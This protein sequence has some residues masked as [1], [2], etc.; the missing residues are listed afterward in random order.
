MNRSRRSRESGQATLFI[1]L[2]LGLFL[3]GSLCLAFDLSNMWFHRQAAQTAADAACTAGAMD[4]LVDAQGGATGHQGFTPGTAFDCTSGGRPGSSVC[5]YALKNGYDSTNAANGNLVSVSFPA[6]A[7]GVD[8]PPPSIAPTPFIRVDVLD[9]VQTF[10]SG[11]LSGSTTQ[12]VRTFSTCGV[13]LA[14]AP[15]PLIVLDPRDTDGPTLDVQGNPVVSIYGG[16]QRS[17]QVNSSYIGAVN[18]GGSASVDLSHGGP[19]NP[20][21]GSDL[22]VYGGPVTAPGGFN[23]GTTGNWVAPAAPINDPFA[24]V[25]APAKPGAPVPPAELAALG[26]ACSSVPCTVNFGVNGCP[27]ATCFE[28]APGYYPGGIDVQGPGGPSNFKAAIFDPGIY[29]IEN[30]FTARSNSCL[31]PSTAL[32][33]GSGGTLFYFAGT[34]SISVDSNSGKKCPNDTATY[35]NTNSGTGSLLYG[36]K[37]TAA[38]QIPSNLPASLS[39]SVLLGPCHLPTE[40]AICTPN[41]NINYG[42]PQGTSGPLGQQRGFLFFQNRGQNADTNPEWTG[43]GQF[44]LS[45][46]M[47]FHQCVTTGSDTGVNCN[48]ATAYHDHLTLG[49][50]AGSG[51]Y[52]LGQIVAD[53]VELNGTS[54]LTM[55]LN[56]AS[57]F[58]IL[59]ASLL[60]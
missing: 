7:F 59:K 2:V 3:L 47:Y 28:Y 20:P 55:D 1:V 22:A 31:R 56:P 17:I 30:G 36:A 24:Q 34:E 5:Q 35:F 38:S 6:S 43:G 10:F 58:T 21:T 45:G 12:D 15:I 54:G 26:I 27:T 41:C 44:L 49:G 29:Y 57:V 33:D 9:H 53:Q 48:A 50:N 46:T 39:G 37:C 16:P 4:L 25:P 11:L 60:Q 23:P 18:I 14:Q 40:T 42:D 19:A 51:T 52:V 8:A 13:V 32:G